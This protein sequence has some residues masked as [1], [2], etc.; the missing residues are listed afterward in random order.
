MKMHRFVGHVLVVEI[1]PRL[2][3]WVAAL[4]TGLTLPILLISGP[5]S[6]KYGRKGGEASS[7]E[8]SLM[9]SARS[10]LE[11]SS[12]W[13]VHQCR[14][15]SHRLPRLTRSLS[16]SLLL[17]NAKVKPC[18]PPPTSYQPAQSDLR[19]R[20]WNVPLLPHDLQLGQCQQY[21]KMIQQHLKGGRLV[22][23]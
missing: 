9:V 3:S 10:S 8:I 15:C 5:L 19:P 6:D 4:E 2:I 22:K 16:S 1:F 13:C 14:F 17:S 18:P 23:Q 20:W 21:H 12:C 7:L 11:R